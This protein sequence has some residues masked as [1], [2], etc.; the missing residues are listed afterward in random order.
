[1]SLAVALLC[2]LLLR[3]TLT[4]AVGS[5]D[6]PRLAITMYTEAGN[7]VQPH[8]SESPPAPSLHRFFLALSQALFGLL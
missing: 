5:G 7:P 8:P 6:E 3:S 1:M 2:P 4:D